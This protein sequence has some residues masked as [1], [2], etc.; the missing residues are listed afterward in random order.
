[1][2][3]LQQGEGEAHLAA[4]HRLLNGASRNEAVDINIAALADAEGAVHGLQPVK[5]GWYAEKLSL[6]CVMCKCVRY[7]KHTDRLVGND[8]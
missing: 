1:V 5:S 3:T 6:A 7:G 2:P 8:C 4:V